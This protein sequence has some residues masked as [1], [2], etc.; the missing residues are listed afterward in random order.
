MSLFA[1][2]YMTIQDE[3]G[4]PVS[5][6]KLFFYATGTSTPA[7]VYS[8]VGLTTPLTNPVVADSAGRCAPVYLAHTAIYRC[9]VTTAAGATIRDVDPVDNALATLAASSGSAGIG[10]IQAGTG[11][12]ART[13]QSKL[14]DVVSVKDFGAVGDGST[15]DTSALQ[16]AFDSGAKKV[17]FPAGTYVASSGLT[18]P[19]WLHIEGEASQPTIGVGSGATV[20]KFTQTSGVALT[21]G[22]SP[23]I[24]KMV[25]WNSGGSYNDTTKTLSGTTA[26]ALDLAANNVVLNEVSFHLWET[27]IRFGASSFYVKTREVEFNRCTNGYKTNGTAPYDVH[28]DAPIS[29][30]TTN[31]FAGQTAYPARNVKVFGGSVEGYQSVASGV[32]DYTSFGTYYETISQRAGAYGIDPGVN[33]ASVSLFGNTIYLTHTSRFVNLSGLT[34][35][36]LSGHGNQFEG[37]GGATTICYYLPSTGSVDLGGDLFGTGHNNATLYV[38]SISNLAKFN[39]ITMPLLP[40]ANTQVGYSGMQ[41]IGA[42][43][44]ISLGLAAAPADKTSGMTV[45]ADGDTWDPLTRAS[46]RPYWVIWQGDRWFALSGA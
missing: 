34:N 21:L 4:N 3:D 18:L 44:F 9:K 24:E 12:V 33:G 17:I 14:R 30:D 46:G 15:D 7:S 2:P 45:L 38:D 37:A 41:I 20:L 22:H 8:D 28:I 25:I 36:A 35:C 42:R 23:L 29:R 26:I 31:F 1:P 40:A 27:C 19:D 43:G 10:F 11:A 16:L 6:G 13:V 32:L 5:G 39:G